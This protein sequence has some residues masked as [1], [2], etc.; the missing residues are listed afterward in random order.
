MPRVRIHR[1]RDCHTV[2]KSE[3][4]CCFVVAYIV[5]VKVLLGKWVVFVIPSLVRLPV[6]MRICYQALVYVSVYVAHIGMPI[7]YNARD[8]A[9]ELK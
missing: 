7:R 2:Q 3:S 4:I 5:K 6:P 8:H 1:Q 9:F